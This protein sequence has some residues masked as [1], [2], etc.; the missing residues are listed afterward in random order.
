MTKR[1]HEDLKTF[2]QM[3]D[4]WKTYEEGEMKVKV[5]NHSNGKY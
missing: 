4:L 1:D 3:F 5:H 2:Y